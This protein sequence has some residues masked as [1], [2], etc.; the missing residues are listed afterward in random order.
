MTSRIDGSG[1]IWRVARFALFTIVLGVAGFV[2]SGCGGRT[3]ETDRPVVSAP[4]IDPD[5]SPDREIPDTIPFQVPEGYEAERVA[6]WPLVEHPMFACFDDQGRLYVAGSSGHHLNADQLKDALPDVIRRL[7]DADGDGRFDTSTVFADKLTFPQG[8][9]WHDGAVFT[10]SPPS[11]W[12]LEDTDGDGKVDQRQELVTGFPFTGIADDLH[13]PCLG[14][15]GRLYWGV[16]RFDYAIRR[17]GGPLIRQ[18]KAP[19]IMRSRPDGTETEVY[20]AAMGNPVE[21]AFSPEG[22]PFA[23]GTF[24]APE[25]MGEGLRDAII[26][27][28]VGGVYSV[29]D[30]ALKEDPRTGD[31]LP[32]LSHLGVAAGSGIMR[33]RGGPFGDEDNLNLYSALFNLHSVER[34]HIERDGATFTARAEPFLTSDAVDF[35]PTDVLEDADGSILVVDTGGWFRSCPTSQIGKKRVLGGIYRVRRVGTDPPDDPRGLKTRPRATDLPAWIKRLDDPRFAVRDEAISQLAKAGAKALPL[36]RKVVRKSGSIRAKRD[37]LWTLARIEGDEADALIRTALKDQD[38]G[39]RLTAATIA[40][41]HRDAKAQ[42]RLITMVKTDVPQVRREAATALGRIGL[43]RAV[44]SLINGLQSNGGPFLDHALIHALIVIADRDATVPALKSK[45]P[46]IRRGA[47]IALDQMAGGGLTPDQVTPLLDPNEP[48]VRQAAIQVIASRPE[49]ASEMTGLFQTWLTLERPSK[50]QRENFRQTLLPFATAPPIQALIAEALPSA[51]TPTAAKLIVLETIGQVPADQWPTPWTDAL[52]FVLKDPDPLVLNQAVATVLAS[53]VTT[54]DQPLLAL[55]RDQTRSDAVRIAALETIAPRL[56]SLEPALLTLL[57]QGTDL[58][59]PPLMRLDAARALGLSPLNDA[60]LS[61]LTRVVAR[62]PAMV[63]PRLLPAF[64][65][66]SNPKV[67]AA[68]L[69]A[70]SQSP[71]LSGLSLDALRQTLASYPLEIRQAGENLSSKINHDESEREGRIGSLLPT[72]AGGDPLRGRE[73]F[74]SAKAACSTCHTVRTEGGAIGPDLSKIGQVRTQRD[75]LEAI[76][77]PSASFARGYEPF[78]VSTHD[79]RILTGI[80]PRETAEAV[81]LATPDRIEIRLRRSS[82]E[83][84]EPGR[85]SVMPQGLE[86]NLAGRDLADLIAFLQSL[87]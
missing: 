5:D 40:A 16:G 68:L 7:E 3:H 42:D 59:H 82:I 30:R 29:R 23:C 71:G 18:G 8:V 62:A 80:I 48:D 31:F 13:G 2:G 85:V 60:Q 37:A 72:L 46:R 75:L 39:V 35:H 22:E 1:S 70:L 79:G 61:T 57:I 83:D 77:Y 54:L 66:S 87:K 73:V 76:L 58:S 41:L 34:H 43:A 44:P 27:C 10:A 67:G 36:L 45:D 53:G 6:V 49:W 69:A 15:D 17:P 19:L 28:V 32:P 78:V 74:F 21:V 63:L 50:R 55:A 51:S 52:R 65:R 38:S 11:L 84:I 14:P 4:Q 47:L 25:A 33:A 56:P 64:V 9:L 26:H 24:L 81:F 86:A 12:R 20:S